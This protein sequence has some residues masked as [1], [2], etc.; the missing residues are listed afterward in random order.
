MVIAD[1]AGRDVAVFG[2]DYGDD[3]KVAE[4]VALLVV[5]LASSSVGGRICRT[6]CPLFDRR[7]GD[8]EQVCLG[9]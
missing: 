1:D 8:L 6:T 2:S 5:L 9:G 4:S 7:F 3:E